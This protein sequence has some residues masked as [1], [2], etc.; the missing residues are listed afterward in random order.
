MVLLVFL[1]CSFLDILTAESQALLSAL[2]D[3]AG[4]LWLNG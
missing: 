2:Q 4:L 3:V 1:R